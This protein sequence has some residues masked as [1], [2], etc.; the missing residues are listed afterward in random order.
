MSKRVRC[1]ASSDTA[2]ASGHACGFGRRITTD[3][4]CSTAPLEERGA[5]W[6][7]RPPIRSE[8]IEQS[9]RK[10]H[11][12]FAPAFGVANVQNH[13]TAVDVIDPQCARLAYAKP[14]PV[15]KHQY[16]S[17]RDGTHCS[18]KPHHVLCRQQYR[19]PHRPLS[20][21]HPMHHFGP[22]EHHVV[23]ES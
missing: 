15:R 22:L 10:H 17:D 2:T 20:S 6:T 5:D 19:Q 14:S 21:R 7:L 13:S 4:S 3:R 9:R 23:K 16:G 8:G 12:P 11:V 18:Q 1:Y